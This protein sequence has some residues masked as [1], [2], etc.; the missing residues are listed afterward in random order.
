MNPYVRRRGPYRGE[1]GDAVRMLGSR[2]CYPY[3][4]RAD[5]TEEVLVE[6][7]AGGVEEAVQTID[8]YLDYFIHQ[9]PAA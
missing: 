7:Y 3:I 1:L 2:P 4:I 9:A 5:A 6:G 8:L